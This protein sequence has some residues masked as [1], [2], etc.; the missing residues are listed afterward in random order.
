MKDAHF[1]RRFPLLLA[2]LLLFAVLCSLG[3]MLFRPKGDLEIQI[4]PET[5][6]EVVAP[7]F[8]SNASNE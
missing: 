6:I 1:D 8:D 5:V 2:A 4:L 7:D 3:L